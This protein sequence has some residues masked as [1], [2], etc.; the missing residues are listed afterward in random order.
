MIRPATSADAAYLPLV[1][2]SAGELFRTVGDYAWIADSGN[3][4]EP[5]YRELIDNGAS[6]VAQTIDDEPIGFLCAEAVDGELHI[7]ELSV[8]LAWQGQG[9]GRRLLETAIA[10]AA[11]QGLAA[12]TLTTFRTL[13]WN[14]PFY[15]SAGFETVSEGR[16][17]PRLAAI[18]RLEVEKGLPP[19]SRCAMRRQIR[20]A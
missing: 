2:Q 5:R 17:D 4:T 12:V 10:W 16:L 15:A 1:E 20:T 19:G 6:W 11:G 8:M 3:M 7:Q 13:P 18:L 14:E 9:L